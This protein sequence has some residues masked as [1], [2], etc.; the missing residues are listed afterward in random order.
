MDTAFP[1]AAGRSDLTLRKVTTRIVRVPLRFTLGTSADV[2]RTVP[3]VLADLLT[4]QGITGRAYAFGY[5]DAGATAIAALLLEVGERTAGLAAAPLPLADLLA[6]RYRLLGVTGAVR[7]ALST[8]DMALWDAQAQAGNCSLADLLGA[9]RRTM[10]AYDSRGL[11]LMPPGPL[12]DEALRLIA[13]RNLPAI[14]LR[15]GH[16]TLA[17]DIAAVTA[18]RDALPASVGL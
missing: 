10:R 14:K 17:E 6:R 16:P 15:L 7:M 12:V 1:P 8:F 3:M 11:G 2:V 4:D 9:R 18:V 13:D 5:T